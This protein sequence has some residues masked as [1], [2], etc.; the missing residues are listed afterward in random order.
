MTM[1]TEK[2]IAQYTLNAIGGNPKVLKYKDANESSE[3]DIFIGVDRPFEGVSTYSTIGLSNFDIGMKTKEGKQ[4]RVEF[5]GSSASVNDLFGNI[6]SSCAFNIIN[7]QY[8]VKPGTVFPNVISEYYDSPTMKHI[9]FSAPFL[10]ENLK[11]LETST[12]HITWLMTIPISDEE[13]EFLKVNGSE[14]LEELFEEKDIDIFDLTRES[15]V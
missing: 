11:S 10:W 5:V 12:A 4:L 1:T 6:V 3:I 8:S 7:S 13:F 2:K 15:V 14:K 9:L